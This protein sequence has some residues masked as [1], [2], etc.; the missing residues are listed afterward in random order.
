MTYT[1]CFKA[2]LE[3]LNGSFDEQAGMPATLGKMRV[4]SYLCPVPYDT[5]V[6]LATEE[7]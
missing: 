1:E 4:A 3:K 2:Q 7:Q 5:A 6:A